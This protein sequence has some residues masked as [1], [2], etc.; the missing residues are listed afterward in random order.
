M[1]WLKKSANS[2][3][4]VNQKQKSEDDNAIMIFQFEIC[5]I[6]CWIINWYD[7]DFVLPY[8]HCFFKKE[9]QEERF[10]QYYIFK[11][12]HHYAVIHLT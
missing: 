8:F 2:V 4:S 11:T 3:L 9:L 6:Y 1:I 10:P 12:F 7:G 5:S